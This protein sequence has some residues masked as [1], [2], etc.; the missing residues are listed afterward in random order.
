M[1]AQGCARPRTV[2]FFFLVNLWVFLIWTHVARHPLSLLHSIP[3]IWIIHHISLF[4]NTNS[5]SLDKYA[6]V[7]YN[8]LVTENN[9][10][11]FRADEATLLTLERLN[12]L[13]EEKFRAGEEHLG[14]GVYP[15]KSA[16]IRK[17]LAIAAP[18]VQQGLE[19]EG[20]VFLRA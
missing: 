9:K 13:A 20:I 15:F 5:L 16:I 17:A 8:V 10:M 11:M 14:P 1:W 18:A 7:V 6:R 3:R 12:T 4:V 2:A 19:E